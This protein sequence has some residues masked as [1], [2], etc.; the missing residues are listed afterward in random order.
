M[1]GRS[2][3]VQWVCDL[4]RTELLCGDWAE[5]PLPGEDALIRKYGVS[6]GIIAT[7]DLAR[8]LGVPQPHPAR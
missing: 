5:V 2:R 1:P 3:T 4:L 6:R 8:A 7:V